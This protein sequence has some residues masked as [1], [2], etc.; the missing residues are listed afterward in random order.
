[1]PSDR[2]FWDVNYEL[3]GTRRSANDHLRVEAN[4]DSVGPAIVR[5]VQTIIH[6]QD[7]EPRYP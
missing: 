7:P 5:P 2:T 1:M 4:L 3:Y 6:L